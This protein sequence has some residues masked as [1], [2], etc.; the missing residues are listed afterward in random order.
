MRSGQIQQVFIYMIASLI[1]V[2]ILYFGY[3]AVRGFTKRQAELAYVSFRTEL[4]GKIGAIAPDFGSVRLES[5]DLPP[6]IEVVCFV[7][8]DKLG[9]S[10]SLPSELAKSDALKKEF[11]VLRE[12]VKGSAQLNVWPLPGGEPWWN[13][14]IEVEPGLICFEQARGVVSIR[15]EGLGDRA[16]IGRP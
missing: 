2:L 4:D 1:I 3:T 7:D 8:P 5:F 6:G 11:G 16:K 9:A 15:L 14:K 10:L 13:A 12:S